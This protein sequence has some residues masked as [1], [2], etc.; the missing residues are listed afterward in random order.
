VK[1]RKE[2]EEKKLTVNAEIT[3]YKIKSNILC[4]VNIHNVLNIIYK[5]NFFINV[6]ILLSFDGYRIWKNQI[7]SFSIKYHCSA[8]ISLN[9][10]NSSLV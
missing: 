7:W 8:L 3:S 2:K 4:H 9:K 10:S 5:S 6:E 1:F